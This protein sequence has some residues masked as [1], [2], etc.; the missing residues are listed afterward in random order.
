VG[1]GTRNV[2]KEALLMEKT[3]IY[4]YSDESQSARLLANALGIK[5]IKRL[6][7]R[8]KPEEGKT[9][10]NWGATQM[11]DEYAQKCTII[12]NLVRVINASR[13]DYFALVMKN[14][15]EV[16]VPESTTRKREAIEWM[17]EGIVIGRQIVNGH[18]GKGIVFLHE[19]DLDKIPN[20]RVHI[21]KGRVLSVQRKVLRKYD[22]AGNLVN[23]DRV[24]FRVR[25]LKNGFIFQRSNIAPHVDVIDQAT[26]AMNAIGLD[27]GAIDVIWNGKQG[28]A[29]V[30][31]INT[32]PGIMGQTVLDYANAFNRL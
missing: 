8:F 16:R 30:L 19:Y 11:P 6:N 1:W 13:K 32:A 29:Y 15:P 28:K 18:G 5:R 22:D 7:S 25:N 26:K 9:I 17:K 21:F 31:E 24:D 14:Y 27:F 3:W 20:Y 4:P 2:G 10:I 12:N 23:P